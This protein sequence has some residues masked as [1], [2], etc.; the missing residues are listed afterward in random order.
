MTC[1]EICH[2][3]FCNTVG[4]LK[5]SSIQQI[6]KIQFEEH[7]KILRE[8]SHTGQLVTDLYMLIKKHEEI[9]AQNEVRKQ[10]LI[11]FK[12]NGPKVFEIKKSE[13]KVCKSCKRPFKN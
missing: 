3:P 10:E 8:Y 11:D 5:L 13:T 1:K 6:N 9:E 12:T 7:I 4:C 2:R